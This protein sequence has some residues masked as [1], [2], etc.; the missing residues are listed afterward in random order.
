MKSLQEIRSILEEN[1]AYFLE[2]YPIKSIGIFGSYVKND[3]KQTSDVD[4][5]VEFT[6]SPGIAFIDLADELE[7][8]LG[9]KVDLVSKKGIKPKYWDVIQ[10]TIAYV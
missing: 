2:K 10:N 9:I 4:I 5:I 6:H 1:K 8:L 3:Q 7:A